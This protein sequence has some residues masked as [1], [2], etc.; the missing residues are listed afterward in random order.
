MSLFNFTKEELEIF[1]SIE[2]A[3]GEITEE[4]E[5]RL[6]ELQDMIFK[7]TD[8]TISF[9]N[10]LDARNN[11]LEKYLEDISE[12]IRVNNN[13]RESL[14]KYIDN[15]MTMRDQEELKGD[16]YSIKKRKKALLVNITDESKIPVE[17]VKVK[18]TVSIDK[19]A[20]SKL[21][22]SGEVIEG[23]ELKESDKQSFIIKVF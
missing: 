15:V 21:L 4:T 17:F 19:A 6:A 3:G 1:K 22:K 11:E 20:I 7:K 8:R 18:E 2:N 10:H 13:K 14:L 5:L 12:R 16:L 9:I 23:A